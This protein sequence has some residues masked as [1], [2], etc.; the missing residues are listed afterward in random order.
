VRA[1]SNPNVWANDI[2]P[3]ALRILDEIDG[4][5]ASES[6]VFLRAFPDLA[7]EL[8]NGAQIRLHAVIE[9]WNPA[10]NPANTIFAGV[11]LQMFQGALVDALARAEPDRQVEV[12][13]SYAD[14]ALLPA[15]FERL[16]RAGSYRWAEYCFRGAILPCSGFID[17]DNLGALLRIVRENGQVWDAAHIPSLLVDFVGRLASRNQLG[18]VEPWLE[19]RTF[20][21]EHGQNLRNRFQRVWDALAEK[22]LVVPEPAAR[23]ASPHS[24]PTFHSPLARGENAA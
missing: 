4:A 7:G 3:V 9:N 22:G 14:P 13:Q 15:A 10:T 8:S 24:T 6:F 18:G 17:G 21:H 1:R 2:R 20:V 23:P 11:G 16:G 5:N 12:I 19:L